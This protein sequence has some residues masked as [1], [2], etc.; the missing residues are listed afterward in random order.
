MS[1]KTVNR[2]ITFGIKFRPGFD[3]KLLHLQ[4]SHDR[5]TYNRLL[6]TLK[7]EYK[8][9]GWVNCSRGR[10]SKWY[11]EM[12][13]KHSFLRQT[14]SYMSRKSLFALGHHYEQYVETKRLKAAGIKPEAEF[15]EPHFKRYG[16]V[17]YIRSG[18]VSGV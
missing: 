2:G 11:T 13:E 8:R 7:A 6:E 3:M 9:Y 10:I 12:R 17:P 5:W 4:A 14:V 1:Y 18:M 16:K 15:G